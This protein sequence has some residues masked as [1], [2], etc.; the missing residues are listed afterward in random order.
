MSKPIT[1]TRLIYKGYTI[2][3][4]PVTKYRLYINGKKASRGGLPVTGKEIDELVKHAK[5]WIDKFELAEYEPRENEKYFI[6]KFTD[7]DRAELRAKWGRE[8]K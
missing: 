2:D 6:F 8:T 1:I 3:V 7:A 4:K 5:L